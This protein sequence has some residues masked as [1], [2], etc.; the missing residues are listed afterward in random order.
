MAVFITQEITKI[1]KE[2]NLQVLA[3]NILP[4]HV[5]MILDCEMKELSD[6]CEATQR[7]FFK[8]AE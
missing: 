3:Y 4:D 5:H 8:K 1:V 6:I 7:Q 2:L